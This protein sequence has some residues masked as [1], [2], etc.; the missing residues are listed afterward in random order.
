MA[1]VHWRGLTRHEEYR[2]SFKDAFKKM[3]DIA[4]NAIFVVGDIV[5]SKTQGIAPELIS[6]LTWWFRELDSIATTYI[7]LGNHDGLITNLDREDAISPII[8]ALNLK[9]TTLIKGSKKIELDENIEISNFCPFDSEGWSSVFPS[10][11]KINIALFHGPV[12]G[13]SSDDDWEIDSDVDINFF[14]NYDFVFLGDIHKRQSLDLDGRIVYCGSTIQQNYG[15]TPDKGFTVWEIN[16]RDDFKNYHVEVDHVNPFV[17]LD[18]DGDLQDLVSK[19]LA[20]RHGA[21]FRIRTNELISQTDIKQLY[22]ILKEQ[23]NAAEIVFKN[24]FKNEINGLDFKDNIANDFNIK[25]PKSVADLV[26]EYHSNGNFGKETLDRIRDQ[27]ISFCDKIEKIDGKTNCYWSIKK[28]EFDNT[29]GYGK[30]NIIDFENLEGITGIFG[31]NRVGKSSICGTL[32]YSLFNTTDRGS[33]PN[34]HIVN[35]RKGH[36]SANLTFAK[37]GKLYRIERQT[38]KKENKKKEVNGITNLNLFEVD[39]NG[40]VLVDLCDEQRRETDKVLRD[41]I[42]TSDDFLLTSFAAQGE[43]NTFIEQKATLR[44]NTLTRFLEL[45]V[46]EQINEIAK[47]ESQ[48]L[49]HYIKSVPSKDY[50]SAIQNEVKSIESLSLEREN[51]KNELSRIQENIKRIELSLVTGGDNSKYTPQ[52]LREQE[53]RLSKTQKDLEDNKNNLALIE[54]E[55]IDLES[56]ISKIEDLRQNFPIEDLKESLKEFRSLETQITRVEHESDKEKQK[57]KNLSKQVKILD[58]V[59]CGDDYPTCPFIVDAHKAKKSLK[60][61]ND[62]L[63][64]IEND[65]EELKK[66]FRK[67]SIVELEEKIERYDDFIKK[68]GNYRIQ[69]SN[70]E[71]RKSEIVIKINNAIQQI[72]SFVSKIDEMKSNLSTDDHAFQLSKF[73]ADLIDQK[74]LEKSIQ[75]DLMTISEKIGLSQS[76]AEKLKEEHVKMLESTERCL[77]YDSIIQATSKNG[78]PLNIIR[79]RLPLIN[80]EIASILQNVAGFTV[81]LE[82]SDGSNDMDI[83]INYGDSRRIIECSSGMEKMMA[84]LAIRVALSNVSQLPKSDVFIIDE[85]FGALDATNIEA[86]NRFLESLKKWFRCILIISHVDAVKDSVDN[87]LEITRINGDAYVKQN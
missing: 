75:D 66:K 26:I 61:V 83:Y 39:N 40:N 14:N 25:D 45:D 52:E 67:N 43:M 81:E 27:T 19:A 34:L 10:P 53:F 70:A 36:C 74:K 73:R 86:C 3:R 44:K 32:M 71:L 64:C 15:E 11:S 42:G 31:Q 69:K 65:L 57:Q 82:S 78:I 29:F 54:K 62:R 41:L 37:N 9:R 8:N 5:H 46:F 17:T 33:M 1:D 23:R 28:L 22:A 80:S 84:S 20:F 79:Q 24:D 35:T 87:V 55:I 60:A 18:W 51:L 47:S 68:Q 12:S 48:G 16:S 72:S 7:S 30:G 13:C 2:E 63:E 38:V 21:R 58:D 56:K 85:G 76:N 77:I 49:R 50:D 4:P 59:P 6:N